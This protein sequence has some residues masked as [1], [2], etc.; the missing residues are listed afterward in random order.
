MGLRHVF[1]DSASALAAILSV[2][3][4]AVFDDSASALAAILSIV[5]VALV[6]V[7]SG[8]DVVHVG[9]RA[10]RNV[11]FQGYVPRVDKLRDNLHRNDKRRMPRE[12]QSLFY[13]FCRFLQYQWYFRGTIVVLEYIGSLLVLTK[14]MIPPT[15]SLRT[16]HNTAAPTYSSF[17]RTPP[18]CV[19]LVS[20]SDS[21]RLHHIV[22]RRMPRHGHSPEREGVR[23]W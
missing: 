10:V 13:C 1:V 22:D 2:I 18:A 6:A 20:L 16:P 19:S 9:H 17:A 15:P 23:R 12:L 21:A 8:E 4:V 5:A 14:C 3:A 7:R 11:R